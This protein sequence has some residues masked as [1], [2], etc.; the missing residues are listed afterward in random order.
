MNKIL[1]YIR[2]FFEPKYFCMHC[3]KKMCCIFYGFYDQDNGRK[4]FK[5]ACRDKNCKGY[6][7]P[8]DGIFRDG[9]N[10]PILND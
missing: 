7:E 10:N 8:K 6:E 2:D 4:T 1:T 9:Y 5:Y 3:G